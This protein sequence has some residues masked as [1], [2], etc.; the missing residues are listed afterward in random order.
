[1][2]IKKL[3]HVSHVGPFRTLDSTGDAKFGENY[4]GIFASNATGKTTLGITLEAAAKGDVQ[5]ILRHRH[6]PRP[7][8]PA[9]SPDEAETAEPAEAAAPAAGAQPSLPAQKVRIK[10]AQDRDDASKDVVVSYGKNGWKNAPAARVEMFGA[11]FVHDNVH[12]GLSITK[13]HQEGLYGFVLGETAK[14]NQDAIEKNKAERAALAAKLKGVSSEIRARV[15]DILTVD[16]VGNFV[17]TA[18]QGQ[19]PFAAAQ[20]AVEAAQLEVAIAEKSSEILARQALTGIETPTLS[21][22]L[23]KIAADLAASAESIGEAALETVFSMHCSK[24]EKHGVHGAQQWLKTG[25]DA[26]ADAADGLCPYCG[27][28]ASATDLA[29]SYARKFNEAF[30]ALVGRLGLYSLALKGSDLGGFDHALALL[31]TGNSQSAAFWGPKIPDAQFPD[32]DALPKLIELVQ[33]YRGALETFAVNVEYK[34]ENPALPVACDHEP[35]TKAYFLLRDAVA[36]YGKLVAAANEKIAQLKRT[37]PDL[38][39]AQTRLSAAH[40]AAKRAQPELEPFMKEW[41]E[42]ETKITALEKAFKALSSEEKREA[43]E[44]LLKYSK[45]VNAYLARFRTAFRIESME[46]KRP[47]AATVSK[48]EYR[49]ELNGR[50]LETA[51]KDPST[52]SAQECLSEGDKTAV[53]LA[54]FMAKTHA[55]AEIGEKIVIFD[56]PFTCFDRDRR[57][58]IVD[59]IEETAR[60]AKQVI[61]LSHDET[62]LYCLD[63]TVR[64][65]HKRN[66]RLVTSAK[67]GRAMLEPLDLKKLVQEDYFRQVDFLENYVERPRAEDRDHALEKVRTVLESNLQFRYHIIL[68]ELLPERTQRTLGRMI[69][70]LRESPEAVF[71]DKDKAAVLRALEKLNEES[72]AV[73][74][75]DGSPVEHAAPNATQSTPDEVA[76]FAQDALNLIRSRI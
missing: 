54:F 9:E 6:L 24:L 13:S 59:I 68:E 57:R 65:T 66:L 75:G 61:V 28:D 37:L 25:H 34:K 19:D 74:H 32:A 51:P 8:A 15:G 76:G 47:A 40:L 3:E 2:I 43:K 29:K 52:P 23:R 1:M 58:A 63:Q 16:Q 14:R 56:D 50:S 30:N 70:K 10:F 35:V 12:S 72:R 73:H 4:T 20:K 41:R 49:L 71:R 33:N 39:G 48:M 64:V 67:D 11:K 7:N 38:P 17:K 27:Q 53:A 5:A 21:Q 44:F 36:D 62:F 45:D 26:A 55:D 42:T 46:G 22:D 18:P 31:C 60:K 69:E